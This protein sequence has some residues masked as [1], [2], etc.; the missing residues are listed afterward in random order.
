MT[1]LSY[2]RIIAKAFHVLVFLHVPI[3]EKVEKELEDELKK[4]KKCKSIDDICKVRYSV[5]NFA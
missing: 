5:I 3:V 1:Y 2:Q 4:A